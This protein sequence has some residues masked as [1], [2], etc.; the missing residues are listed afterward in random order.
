MRKLEQQDIVSYLPYKLQVL[1]DQWHEPMSLVGVQGRLAYIDCLVTDISMIRP[2]LHS[3]FDL[4]K[5]TLIEG[6]NNNEPFVPI[7]ELG[8]VL[9]GYRGV[10]IDNKLRV[11]YENRDSWYWDNGDF[12]MEQQ[13][14]DYYTNVSYR[15][16]YNLLYQWHFDVNGLIE[17]GL[18]ININTLNQYS[19]EISQ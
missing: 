3:M 12:Y 1:S 14:A 11:G 5:E 19:N 16:A 17:K 18:A 2:F 8:F 10:L 4:T 15:K 13:E 6:Y 9:F 7:I